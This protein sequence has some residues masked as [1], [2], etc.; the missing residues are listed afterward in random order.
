M[1]LGKIHVND[2]KTELKPTIYETLSGSNVILNLA[3]FDTFTMTFTR[4]DGTQFSKTNADGVAIFNSPGSDGVL[5]Y[6]TPTPSIW[7]Q[8]GLWQIR[9]TVNNSV[10]GANFTTEDE[11][12]EVLG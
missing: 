5:H 2:V 7:N 12:Q 4:P 3:N 11:P 9:V 1:V 6:I 8:A 10:S